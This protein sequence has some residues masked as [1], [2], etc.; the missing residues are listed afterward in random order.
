MAKE[1]KNKKKIEAA[2]LK[3]QYEQLKIATVAEQLDKAV[4]TILQ[5]KEE[6]EPAQFE[7]AMAA[8]AARRKDIEAEMEKARLKYVAKLQRLG[9]PLLSDLL[10]EDEED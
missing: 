1:H 9:D 8:V 10:D 6:L 7:D 4:A 2:E 5:Y 3:F